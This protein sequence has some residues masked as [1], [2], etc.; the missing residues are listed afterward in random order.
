MPIKLTTKQSIDNFFNATPIK[1]TEQ[2]DDQNTIRN[3]KDD[4]K[5]VN[6]GA[7]EKISSKF[8]SINVEGANRGIGI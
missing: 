7:Q 2:I 1:S 5:Q 6:Y 3:N 4:I 8:T